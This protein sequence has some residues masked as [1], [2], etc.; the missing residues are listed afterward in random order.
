MLS[1]VPIPGGAAR[2]LRS[3][4]EPFGIPD[5]DY[6]YASAARRV[7]QDCRWN[8]RRLTRKLEPGFQ[9]V[10]HVGNLIE[11][12]YERCCVR[13]FHPDPNL[14]VSQACGD[15]LTEARVKVVPIGIQN[16]SDN[17]DVFHGVVQYFHKLFE[18]K[19]KP[20]DRESDSRLLQRV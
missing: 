19:A 17:I 3:E 7:L 20:D 11:K 12:L 15:I 10:Q 14:S 5:A 2:L 13:P 16:I 9:I 6:V 4:V 18:G 1:V 8:N